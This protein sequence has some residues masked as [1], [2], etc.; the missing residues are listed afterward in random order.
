MIKY[1]LFTTILLG[2]LNAYCQRNGNIERVPPKI[3]GLILNEEGEAIPFANIAVYKSIDSTLIKGEA[4]DLDG[5]FG[6]PI[7]PGKYYLKI[8]FLSYESVT[9]SVEHTREG[10]N[11]GSITLKLNSELIDEVEIVAEKSQMQLKL[12]KRVFNVGKDLSNVGTNAAEILDNI[13]SVAVDIEGNI[14][15]RGSENVRV[16]IDGKPST[17]TGGSTADVLRQF[18]GNMIER[19]EVITNPSARYDAEGEVGIINII[20]KKEKKKGTNGSIEAVVGYPDNYRLSYNLNFRQ[21]K[22]NLFTSYGTGYRKSPGG[23]ETFQ[24]FNNQDTSYIYESTNDRTRASL[25]HNFRLGADYFLNKKNTITLSG[26]YRYSDQ[27]NIAEYEYRDLYDTRELFQKVTRTD[28]EDEVGNGL[29]AALN[30]RKTFSKK[31]ELFTIDF[32]WS[33]SDDL[34]KSNIDEYNELLNSEL[35]QKTRNVE[36]NR[37]FL[38]QSDYVLPIKK[39]GKFETGIRGNLRTI[40]NKFKVEELDANNEFQ[41]LPEFN[42]D[43]EFQEKIYA[44]YIMFGN[45]VNKFSYQLGLRGELSEIS[46]EL[47]LTD[48]KNEWNYDNLFPSAHFSYELK[49]KNSFQLSYSR[50]INRPS[51]RFLLPFQTFSDQRNLWRGNPDLQPEFTDS[52]ELGYL[53]FFGKGSL[54]S[55]I[56][57]RYRTGVINRITTVNSEGFTE[58]LPVNLSTEN[59]IGFEFTANYKFTKNTSFNSS[60]NIFRSIAEGSYEGIVL[61][62]DVITWSNRSMFKTKLTKEIDFQASINYRAPQKTG[63]GERKS[64]YSIDL[65]ASKDLLDGK[66]TLVASVRDLLNTRKRRSI[67]E[68]ET[69]FSESEFQWRA[70]QFLLSFT[71]RIN[72]KK[73][74][75]GRPSRNFSGGEDF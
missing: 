11:I 48:E 72:Q 6:I 71:Y 56:Y 45:K 17:I 28:V 74:R 22:Y 21:E 41:I 60:L 2:T 1:F 19:V 30:Y 37:N 63:Q 68:T 18:Q 38:F 24:T 32:Q 73:K 5:N 69:L 20:L 70:R 58:R 40:E 61:D 16:L 14:S 34:E 47:K 13:P 33:E 52:Y 36:A 29:E 8:S 43:F 23:G 66:A 15:L 67:T 46:T 62:N 7:R 44:A 51:F 9:K 26:F 57:Y 64:I 54:F 75:G 3:T 39:E 42:N 10:T 53:N 31:D 65:S 55:S 59:N 35:I 4:T 49:D 25:N 12:D 27:E 50:R